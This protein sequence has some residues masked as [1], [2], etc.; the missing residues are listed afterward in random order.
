MFRKSL[1][2]LTNK[3]KTIFPKPNLILTLK[4]RVSRNLFEK[5]CIPKEKRKYHCLFLN[6]SFNIK[7]MSSELFL[8]C[9][10]VFFFVILPLLFLKFLAYVAALFLVAFVL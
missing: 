1:T 3:L 5:K 6:E 7:S 2:T 8:L 4:N 10:I 9:R